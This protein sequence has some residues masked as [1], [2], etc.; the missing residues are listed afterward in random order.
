[1][2]NSERKSWPGVGVAKFLPGPY[3]CSIRHWHLRQL[4]MRWQQSIHTTTWPHG[5][6][7]THAYM[8]SHT[9]HSVAVC[10]A[11]A[12]DKWL[13]KALLACFSLARLAGRVELAVEV[14][15]VWDDDAFASEWDFDLQYAHDKW[16]KKLIL[17]LITLSVTSITIVAFCQMMLSATTSTLLTY[18]R[19]WYSDE[20]RR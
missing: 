4:F 14:S 9:M 1:M 15:V 8:S 11:G 20:A 18:N 3:L 2:S 10:A 13:F 17:K 7:V 6:N 19:T 12:D 16:S 5:W